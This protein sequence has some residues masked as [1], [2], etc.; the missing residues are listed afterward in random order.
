M[1]KFHFKAPEKARKNKI[2]KPKEG[3]MSVTSMP[4]TGGDEESINKFSFSD[5]SFVGS[6]SFGCGGV[7]EICIA[8]IL[9]LLTSTAT[10]EVHQAL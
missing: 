3:K 4:C 5:N 6:N 2:K 7:N 10:R 8:L 9:I 1:Q